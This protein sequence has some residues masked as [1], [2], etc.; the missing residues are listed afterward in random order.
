MSKVLKFCIWHRLP[1]YYCF[2]MDVLS[3][4]D[5]KYGIVL[6]NINLIVI[7]MIITVIFILLGMYLKEKYNRLK[8]RHYG[9]KN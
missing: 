8:I 1:I 5:Y 7:Y 4:I 2:L 6:S 9:N 3:T